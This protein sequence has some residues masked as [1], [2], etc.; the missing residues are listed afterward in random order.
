MKRVL[1]ALVV[2]AIASAPALAGPNE[3]GLQTREP[4]RGGLEGGRVW[5]TGRRLARR[6]DQLLGISAV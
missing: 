3:N 6:T 5:L 2:L 1:M 4:G